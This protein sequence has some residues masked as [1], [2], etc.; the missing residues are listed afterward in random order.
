M[1]RRPPS[2][3]LLLVTDRPR[4][5][6][7][8]MGLESRARV[9]SVGTDLPGASRSLEDAFENV[10][11]I[12]RRTVV[13]VDLTAV[14]ARKICPQLQG[15]YGRI[16]LVLDHR[17]RAASADLGLP[18][19]RLGSLLTEWRNGLHDVVRTRRLVDRLQ[20]LTEPCKNLLILTH[21]NPDPDAIASA[22]G[23]RAVLGRNKQSATIGY[24]G[25]PLSRP[26]NL[27]MLGL[28]DID[29]KR[30]RGDELAA[31]DGIVLVDCQQNVFGGVDIPDVLAVVDHHPE[32]PDFKAPYQHIVPEEGSTATIITRYLRSLDIVP[33]QRLATA[34]LYGVKSDTFF[35]QR[36][37][38]DEDID[39]FMY[40]YPLANINVLRRMEQPEL[41]GRHVRAMGQALA[42]STF[43]NGLFVA[44]T[45]SAMARAEDLAPRLAEIGLQTEGAEWAAAYVL[46]RDS[47]VI[48]VRNVGYVRHAGRAVAAA[49]GELG[50]AG[51]HRSAARAVV[52]KTLVIEDLGS[53]LDRGVGRWVRRRLTDAIKTGGR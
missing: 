34:L 26:E 33:S 44:G 52:D 22:L 45:T 24:L 2:A 31:F 16:N 10:H 28:L 25:Q 41:P 13:Y 20:K 7:P 9:W 1:A 40:L 46:S 17:C 6:A 49:F 18:V 51:G 37:V 50:S 8:V 39:S 47:L 53:E 27:A 23:M 3:G 38:N 19:A 36:D 48:S 29:L 14:R 42:E 15:R 11:S 4:F 35:L 30:V 21:P 5:V 32:R 12:S 43:R